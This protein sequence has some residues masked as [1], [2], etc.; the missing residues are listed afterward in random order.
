ML[1]LEILCH[2]RIRVRFRDSIV[3]KLPLIMYRLVAEAEV[4]K[5][6]N[7]LSYRG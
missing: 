7:Q 4:T 2:G 5:L 1:G 6:V 3:D